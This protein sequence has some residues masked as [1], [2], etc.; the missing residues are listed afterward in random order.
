MGGFPQQR[1]RGK[2]GGFH[3]T[4][5]HGKVGG[6]SATAAQDGPADFHG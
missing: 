4:R 5:R 3:R 2:V 1:R 6:F